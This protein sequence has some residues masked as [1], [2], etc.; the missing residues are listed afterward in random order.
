MES[1]ADGE[2]IVTP[3]RRLAYYLKER[4]NEACL[5]G[6]LRV[7]RT[8]DILTWDTL[9]ERSFVRDRQA[10]RLHARWLPVS[11]ARLKW[12]RIVRADGETLAVLAKDGLGAAAYRSWQRLHDYLIPVS[13]LVET[14]TA[15]AAALRRWIHRY[16]RWLDAGNWLDPSQAPALLSSESLPGSLRMFGFDSMTPAQEAFLTRMQDA[17]VDIR[18]SRGHARQGRCIKVTLDDEREEIDAAARWAAQRLQERPGDRLALVV[19]GLRERR[20]DVRR[21][22]NAVLE[23]GSTLTGGSSAPSGLFELAAAAPLSSVALVADAFEVLTAFIGGDDDAGAERMLEVRY[24]RGFEQEALARAGLDARRLSRG[25]RSLSPQQLESLA[26]RYDCA[27]LAAALHAGSQKIGNWSEKALPSIWAKRFFE[28]LDS[29]GWPGEALDSAEHQARQRWQALLADFGATEEVTGDLSR[30]EALGVLR[31]MAGQVL[32]EPEQPHGPLLVIDPDTS[33]GMDFN[34]LWLSGLDASR[35]PAPVSPDPFLP[36]S[37][38]ANRA[39]P[40]ATADINLE[41]ADRLFARLC[42]S[43]DEVVVSVPAQDAEARLQPSALVGALQEEALPAAWPTP[44]V[45]ATIFA[46]RPEA[47]WQS[48]SRMP[49]LEGTRTTPGG[50]RVLELQSACGFRAHSEQ[51]L[52]AR[53]LE[54]PQPGVDAATRGSLAH[55]VLEDLWRELGDSRSLAALTPRDRSQRVRQIIEPQLARLARSAHPV[56]ASILQLEAAWLEEQILQLLDLDARR[57]AFTVDNVESSFPLQIGGLALDLRPDR[58]DRLKDG[59]LALIDY[60]TG[61]SARIGAW[62]DERPTLPQLPLYLLAVGPSKVSAVAFGRL[63]AG[64]TGYEGL[65]RAT[66][67]FDELTVFDGKGKTREFDSWEQMLTV[68]RRRLETLADEYRAGDARLAAN[69]SQACAYCQ[70]SVLCR[71]AELGVQDDE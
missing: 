5:A 40:G 34:A 53:V 19:P 65:V 9:I 33:A 57:E 64:Q 32:F 23:P 38:Q 52:G 60:K 15:E 61:S 59:S 66:G 47:V 35:W 70:L 21:A 39:V 28:L 25:Q 71:K 54:Q 50:A 22:L 4:W 30:R 16:R 69:P 51:R 45:A 20:Q 42:S 7:W 3:T 46:A 58:V 8:P 17:R 36:Q 44:S 24:C 37:W 10:G 49:E 2:T 63:R 41:R 31:G 55:K 67:L 62:F 14:D 29:V 13:A 26:E 48:D 27:E 56:T 12:Q 1:L 11:T 68:W 18:K 6:G 43:A